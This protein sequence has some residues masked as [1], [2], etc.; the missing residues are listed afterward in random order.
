[1]KTQIKATI[2]AIALLAMSAAHAGGTSAY[3]GVNVQIGVGGISGSSSN[4]GSTTS[5]A[6]SN[7]AGAGKSQF[8]TE[9]NTGGSTLIGGSITGTGVSSVQEQSS[10]A[11]VDTSGSISGNAQAYGAGGLIDNGAG[12]FANTNTNAGVDTS[13]QSFGGGVSGSIFAKGFGF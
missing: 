10:Y 2:A 6:V 9:A 4:Y 12:S 1:M 8:Q 5:T 13:F 3:G 7:L 11:N